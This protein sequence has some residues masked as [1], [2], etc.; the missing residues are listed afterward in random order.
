MEIA[1]ACVLLLHGILFAA[2]TLAG[3]RRDVAGRATP[4]RSVRAALRELERV[5]KDGM[6]KEASASL[7][8]KTLHELFGDMD[9]DE[10]E[11]A[12]AVAG[13]REEV[14]FVRYAPQL[15]DYSEKLREL[16]ARAADV[17]SRWA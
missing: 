4:R 14:H 17:V 11:R 2:P 16:A 5:G 13:L 9:G 1:A 8:E 10:S 15:G 6:S 7:I 3:R 12:R